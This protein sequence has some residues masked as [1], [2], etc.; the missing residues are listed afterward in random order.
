MDAGISSGC[1]GRACWKTPRGVRTAWTTC[2]LPPQVPQVDA[3]V[4]D[5]MPLPVQELQDSSRLT[6]ISLLHGAHIE[7]SALLQVVTCFLAQP[8]CGR[9]D[10][11]CCLTRMTA[12]RRL[13]PNFC[14]GCLQSQR[15]QDSI[16]HILGAFPAYLA[17][18]ASADLLHTLQRLLDVLMP[19][20]N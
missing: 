18:H 17:R 4:P 5:L 15:G 9:Q 8:A 20:S 11:G 2:P 10:T 6:S 7:Y 13:S 16:L 19:S 3:E 12:C 1:Q 14:I